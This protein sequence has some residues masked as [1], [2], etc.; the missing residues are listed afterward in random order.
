M[1]DTS[2]PSAQTSTQRSAQLHWSDDGQPIS[3]QFDDVYFSRADGLAE[4]RY[5]FL[6]H[7][8][9][10]ERWQAL[11]TQGTT[12]FTIGET[13]F[14]TGLN[15]LAAW[16]LW[17]QL[18]PQQATLH[19]VSV[20]KYPLSKTDLSQALALW[21]EL[22]PLARMLIDAYPGH[23]GQGF[24]RL[25]FDQGRV[26]LT[27]IIDE[28][29]AGFEQLLRSDHPLHQTDNA[30]IDAWFLDG[31]A[32]SKNPEM[33]R[34]ELFDQIARLSCRGTSL[35]TFT[36]AGIV[37]RGLQ[38]VGF[39]VEK[40]PGFG[41]KRE[42]VRA[43]MTQ[44]PATPSADDFPSGAFNARHL[45]PWYLPRHSEDPADREPAA[46]ETPRQAV[47][48]GGGLAGC[49]TARALAQRGWQVTLVEQHPTLAR[50][51]SGNPQGILYAKLSPKQEAL[52]QFNLAALQF[53]QRY[54]QPLWQTLDPDFGAQCGV[55]Q[56][57]HTPKEAELQASLVQ[58]YSHSPAFVQFVDAAQASDIAGINLQQSG[59]FFPAAGWI[60]P[61]SLCQYL[62]AHEHITVITH[63]TVS[64]LQREDNAW[65]LF[66]E[67]QQL[68][69]QAPVTVIATA[70]HCLQ[71]PQTQHLPLRAIRGQVSVL[72]ASEHSGEMNTVIC[73]E[74]YVAPAHNQ[75]HCLGATFN[76]KDTATELRAEDHRHNLDNL[77]AHIP[78]LYAR[79]AGLDANTLEG[80]VA[81][82]C[83]SR[84]YLPL[85]GPTPKLPQFEDDY[86]LL[87]KNAKA[88]IP[89]A[90]SYWP[91][92]YTNV[93]HGSRGLAYT[94]L[95]AELVAAQICGTPL[96]V[97]RTLA[98]ALNPA[99]FI[100]RELIRNQR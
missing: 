50:E 76:L 51:G 95:C 10:S 39:A 31:F 84:D 14:G 92:L 96:P 93:G 21:P 71:L 20:E 36:A 70:N 2:S 1:S 30:K 85:A 28:A 78:D 3:T 5:V 69:A 24:H 37:R 86:Q 17:Q 68:I 45:T 59:L 60:H 72:P 22:A 38:R 18:A 66:D 41:H 33:W 43:D 46:A 54:Y 23:T 49:H 87:R 62:V 52:A 80:R 100:I 44:T 58:A 9:L 73:G 47:V 16:Q 81:F 8:R 27:L 88:S 56:L 26:Q 98:T 11:A 65:Q 7:N 75:R 48:I 61:P 82:R 79:F 67:Q 12:D 13:G 6:Q 89:T 64:K 32:P 77:E 91:G 19:F 74:G 94:P 63:T 4:T 57:A 90:G 55:L 40:V 99:R 25:H 53:A 29:S 83:S 35:A 15:F 34:D 97:S 42:M